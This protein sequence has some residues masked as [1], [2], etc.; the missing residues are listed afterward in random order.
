MSLVLLLLVRSLVCTRSQPL[1][2]FV[3]SLQGSGFTKP[4]DRFTI[5]N[6][7]SPKIL[8]IRTGFH[9]RWLA[10]SILMSPPGANTEN[11]DVP[12]ARRFHRRLPSIIQLQAILSRCP[13]Q[14]QATAG[15][16]E[17]AARQAARRGLPMHEL[18][19]PS[20]SGFVLRT[21]VEEPGPTTPDCD[22]YLSTT[23]RAAFEPAHPSS[24]SQQSALEL[25]DFD[26]LAVEENDFAGKGL[27][28][29]HAGVT[30]IGDVGV[31]QAVFGDLLP[32]PLLPHL[33]DLLPAA[34][35]GF[36]I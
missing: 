35:L 7:P 2:G 3:Y 11:N 26:Q 19:A 1:S 6:C 5:L 21:A 23:H 13:L 15:W 36:D 28:V 27:T 24:A 10:S 25:A 8:P 30:G 16:T 29:D 20:G 34:G 17:C 9:V 4:L 31:V 18:T 33:P 14:D 32:L 12:V 22:S